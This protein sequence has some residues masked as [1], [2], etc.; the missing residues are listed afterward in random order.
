[1]KPSLLSPDLS[2]SAQLSLADIAD[3]K[4]AGFR[5]ILCD[6][7]DGEAPGQ[8]LFADIAGQDSRSEPD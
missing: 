6:R 8:P 1:M 2:A 5:S 3:A 4:D 7:P